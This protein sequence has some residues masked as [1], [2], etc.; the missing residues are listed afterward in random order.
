MVLL[1]RPV[2]MASGV[3]DLA[4]VALAAGALQLLLHAM[5]I[6]RGWWL[7]VLVVAVAYV[8]GAI[9]FLP[10]GIGAN[11]ASLIGVLVGFGVPVGQA[12]AV[13]LLE[14]L[15]LTGVPSAVGC[16]PTQPSTAG[17][18]WAAW[19]PRPGPSSPRPLRLRGGRLSVPVAG[20]PQPGCGQRAR[21]LRSPCPTPRAGRSPPAD[22]A[23]APPSSFPSAWG[24]RRWWP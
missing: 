3:I 11:E 10:G 8:G 15:L 17:C 18:T 21:G 1:T 19:W 24:W 6:D 12:A 16:S 4:R 9:S 23:S 7:A 22:A 14:R 5:N 13:A 2:A 20:S